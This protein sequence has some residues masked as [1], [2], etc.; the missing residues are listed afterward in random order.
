MTDVTVRRGFNT[1]V[2]E[3]D[4]PRSAMVGDDLPPEVCRALVEAL[5]AEVDEESAYEGTITMQPLADGE[6][7]RLRLVPRP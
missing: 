4:M 2:A 6:T 1:P 7:V 5:A 3:T